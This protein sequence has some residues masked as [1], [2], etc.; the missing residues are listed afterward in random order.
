MRCSFRFSSW[1]EWFLK[2]VEATGAI[3]LERL[4]ADVEA[5]DQ[6]GE[7]GRSDRRQAEAVSAHDCAVAA[8]ARD[9]WRR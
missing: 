2:D 1:P 7:L 6:L 5:G 4:E 3:D 8:G 9:R